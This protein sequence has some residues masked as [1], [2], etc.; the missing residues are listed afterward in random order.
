MK[1]VTISDTHCMHREV[2]V[3]DGDVLIH[4][5]DMTGRGEMERL[6]DFCE[7]MNEL[8]HKHKIVIAGN[9]DFCF[10][11]WRRDEAIRMMEEV[12]VYLE[13]SSVVI[14]GVKFYGSPW[15]PEFC[16]WAFNLPR[17]E[18]LREVWSKIEADTDVLIT[19]GPPLGILDKCPGGNVGDEEL[20]KAIDGLNLKYHIFGHIHEGYGTTK[21]GEV[22]HIN[23]SNCTGSYRPINPPITFEIE[24]NG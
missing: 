16:D 18:A 6:L 3:P 20:A 8:P 22:T 9:H 1:I 17:G 2:D 7:W 19:H 12:A 21:A 4:A 15:Q 14:D 5:G 11:N 23:A 13:D 10:E 24:A